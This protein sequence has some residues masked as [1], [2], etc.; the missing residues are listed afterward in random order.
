MI[1][2]NTQNTNRYMQAHTLPGCISAEWREERDQHRERNWGWVRVKQT[3]KGESITA[4]LS[5]TTQDLVS[6][7]GYMRSGELCWAWLECWWQTVSRQLQGKIWNHWTFDLTAEKSVAPLT[8]GL[9]SWHYT[10]PSQR[11][12]LEHWSLTLAAN[13]VNTCDLWC[14]FCLFNTYML[15][16]TH[17]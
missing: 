14:W 15:H 16:C 5:E 6:P 4:S 1:R 7:D 8:W 12:R 9:R 3:I 10:F 11:R 17:F 13:M 2:T